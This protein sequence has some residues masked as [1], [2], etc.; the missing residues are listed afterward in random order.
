LDFLSKEK[1]RR[2]RRRICSK[3][4]K[5][6]EKE[7]PVKSWPSFW[8][9][10][11]LLRVC[12]VHQHPLLGSPMI[13][14]LL[15]NNN[16]RHPQIVF[17]HGSTAAHLQLMILLLLQFGCPRGLWVESAPAAEREEQLLCP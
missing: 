6:G 7:Q 12:C 3:K 13:S 17:S 2:W 16:S 1:G 15:P 4:K 11:L 5:R 10:L 9:H 14:L 8:Y